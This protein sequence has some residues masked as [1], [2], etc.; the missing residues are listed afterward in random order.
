[1]TEDVSKLSAEAEHLQ[2]EIE[3]V[4]ANKLSSEDRELT[5]DEKLAMIEEEMGED[6]APE[7]VE[8]EKEEELPEL[9]DEQLVEFSQ[10]FKKFANEEGNLPNNI[11][12]HVM[13]ELG[14]YPSKLLNSQLCSQADPERMGVVKRKD[15]LEIMRKMITLKK[16]TEADIKAAFAVFD[17]EKNGFIPTAH[18]R[19]ST[20]SYFLNNIFV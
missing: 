3:N 5:L 9:T 6:P 2:K 18:M 20:L 1:M 10:M 14:F 12:G 16:P 15:F 19:L 11:L 4:E 7:E 13:R 8:E 17:K